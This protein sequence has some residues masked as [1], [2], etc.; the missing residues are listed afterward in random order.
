MEVALPETAALWSTTVVSK[1]EMA[2][3]VIRLRLA[4]PAGFIYRAG[5]YISLR[6]GDGLSRNYSLASVPGDP[7]LELHIRRHEQG[8]A[9]RWISDELSAGD[10]LEI[11]G[12]LGDCFYLPGGEDAPMLLIGTGTGLAPLL[13]IARDALGSGHSGR[14]VLYHG[15][16]RA[17]DSYHRAELERLASSH[18][19]FEPILCVSRDQDPPG[20]SAGRADE[21]AFGRFEDL[22]GWRVYL[23][24]APG[25]VKAAKRAAYLAG[26]SMRDIWSDAFEATAAV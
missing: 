8:R 16:R 6:R 5:Q 9:S 18:G 22:T 20:F 10:A 7:W 26:A 14:I 4:V 11:R 12:P 19:S 23:C 21:L 17:E 15:V 3:G 2:P 1:E 25:M 13:G 24:G